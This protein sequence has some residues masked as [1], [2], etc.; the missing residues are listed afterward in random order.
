MKM[1]DFLEFI[2]SLDI[3]E[4][5]RETKFV[6]AEWAVLIRSSK[7]RTIEEKREALQYLVDHYREEDFGDERVNIFG[8]VSTPFDKEM[9]IREV[10]KKTLAVWQ[11][12]LDDRERNEEVFFAAKLTE[13]G[14]CTNGNSLIEYV[15]F[16]DYRDAFTYLS[17]EKQKY[18]DDEDLRDIETIGKIRRIKMG[19]G[20]DTYYFD[21]Q[22]RLVDMGEDVDRLTDENGR[23]FSPL[24]NNVYKVFV[25]LPFQMGDIVK[26]D[27]WGEEP[28][29][30]VISR[31]WKLP[32]KRERIEM[33][34]SLDLYLA[35]RNEFDYTDGT[36][37]C[38]LNYSLCPDEELPED[39]QVLK[40]IRAVRQGKL[41]WYILLHKYGRKELDQV[42]KWDL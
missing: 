6:P 21:T 28:Y 13:K 22:M 5:N 20:C 37:D 25:P 39:E 16:S 29:Y 18:M 14:Y 30:G 42:L 11:D 1:K 7:K 19:G 36:G 27:N 31:D 34:I 4:F 33:W 38:I 10:V 35:D 26:V 8:V 3:R 12:I 17:H 15:F 23:L 41:D 2:D 32:E 24:K 9:P 40:L